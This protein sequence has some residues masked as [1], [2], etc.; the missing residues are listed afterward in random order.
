MKRGI[1]ALF[2]VASLGLVGAAP[3]AFAGAQQ[4]RDGSYFGSAYNYDG[5][6][7]SAGIGRLHDVVTPRGHESDTFQLDGVPNPTGSA[8]RLDELQDQSIITGSVTTDIHETISA[9]EQ[10]TLVCKF[11]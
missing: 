10:A 6:C 5:S 11:N 7:C 1:A 4:V 9:S 2:A 3:A 8:V